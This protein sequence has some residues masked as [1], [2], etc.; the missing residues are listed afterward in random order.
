MTRGVSWSFG[1]KVGSVLVGLLV[2][3]VLARALGPRN[4]GSYAYIVALIGLLSVPTSLGL[5]EYLV[6]EVARYRVEGQW[7]LLRGLL[8]RANQVVGGLALLV[9][10]LA[11]VFVTLTN[12]THRDAFFWAL[13][14][15]FVNA[16]SSLRDSSVRGFRHVVLA[17]LPE[18]AVRPLLFLTLVSALV[19]V[20]KEL[21]VG[22]VFGLQLI[23]STVAFALGS[24][25]LV[26][27]LPVEAKASRGEY[28]TAAWLKAAAP[29]LFLGAMYMVTNR[30]DIVM[31]G[32]LRS[33]AEVGSY[34]I[35]VQGAQLVVFILIAVSTTIGP[36]ISE[37]YSSGDLERLRRVGIIS[38]RVIALVSLPMALL[39]M[40]F[41]RPLIEFVFGMGYA[42]ASKPLAVLCLGQAVNAGIGPVGVILNMTGHERDSLKGIVVAAVLNVALNALLIPRFGMYGAAWA[43]TVSIISWNLALQWFVV[44]RLGIRVDAYARIR[45]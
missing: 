43:T 35:A 45:G 29:F 3:I 34:R 8:T 9:G 33:S 20:G 28:M 11:A 31:L 22:E 41:G 42:S 15:L 2:N 6:R 12:W 4:F 18:L 19:V 30:I 10:G 32:M 7:G 40:F 23:A 25:V 24:W 1:L 37:L 44:K 26:R 14:L 27:T 36:L 17:Q 16:L 38:A 39:F 21:S 13:P 5:P